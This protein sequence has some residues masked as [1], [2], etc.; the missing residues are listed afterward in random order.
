[1]RHRSA[2]RDRD[3]TCEYITSIAFCQYLSNKV[4]KFPPFPTSCGRL[5]AGDGAEDVP[6]HGEP[7]EEQ[8][9][10]GYQGKFDLSDAADARAEP[11]AQSGE[12]GEKTEDEAHSGDGVYQVQV[13][14]P[15]R[16]W[17]REVVA[18]ASYKSGDAAKQ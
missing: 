17:R 4:P 5:H 8:C 1:M 18:R 16:S 6:V 14:V 10:N 11:D 15:S 9:G 3:F 7:A 2:R 12:S 13:F